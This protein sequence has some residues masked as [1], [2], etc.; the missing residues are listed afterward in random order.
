MILEEDIENIKAL[1]LKMYFYQKPQ[2]KSQ[3]SQ[4]VQFRK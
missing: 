3:T 1:A 4:T 2:S